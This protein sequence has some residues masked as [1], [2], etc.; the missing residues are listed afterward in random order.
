M[1]IIL[2]DEIFYKEEIYCIY[3]EY[4]EKLLNFI[5]TYFQLDIAVFVPDS[6]VSEAWSSNNIIGEIIRK[7]QFTGQFKVFD[8]NVIESFEDANFNQ[9]EFSNFFIG[10]I[11]I[12]HEHYE[13]VIIPLSP[14]KHKKELKQISDYVFMVNHIYK[15]LD[16][17]ISNWISDNMYMKNITEPSLENP[18]PNIELCH[19]YKSVQDELIRGQDI[20]SRIPIFLKVGGEV[21]RR[22]TY[23]FDDE[24]SSINT[25]RNKIREIYK[26]NGQNVVHGSIDI[27]SGSIEICDYRGN[28]EDEYGFDNQ[29]HDKHD[30]TGRHDIRLH[31]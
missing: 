18:L 11:N 3:K 2:L 16:S 26:S 7:I 9:L 6:N 15:E 17:N 29:S 8:S 13:N 14:C 23:V 12:L 22:N 27:E 20:S 10:E 5:S 4:F 25:T 31:R 21:L 19:E 28:H 30:S 24:L 1:A